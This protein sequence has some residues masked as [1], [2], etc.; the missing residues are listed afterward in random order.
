MFRLKKANNKDLLRSQLS[1]ERTFYKAFI[2]DLKSAESSVIVEN[3]YLTERR[4]LQ[5][6]KLF[7]K[8][9]KRGTKVRIYT[10]LPNHHNKTLEI[11]AWKAILVLR[12]SGVKVKLCSDL[13]HRKLAVIDEEVLWEGSMN[14]LSQN[15][16]CEII[17]RTES[18]E[19]SKQLLKFIGLK[20]RF[21]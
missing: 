12:H 21:W 3:P 1:S 9:K 2:K 10:R 20:R 6:S 4:A 5:F 7:S 14:I 16:S 17:R 19:L 15:R 13:R 8:L 11:Q 18:E